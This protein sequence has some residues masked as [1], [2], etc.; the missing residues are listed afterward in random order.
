[1]LASCM[2]LCLLLGS[3]P[4]LSACTDWDQLGP[5]M[6]HDLNVNCLDSWNNLLV[7]ADDD[8]LKLVDRVDGMARV[9]SATLL[10]FWAEGLQVSAD[11]AVVWQ[12]ERLAGFHLGTPL[13]GPFFD[14][15]FDDGHV[16]SAVWFQDA[17]FV[18]YSYAVGMWG[19]DQAARRIDLSDPGH[20]IDLG[21]WPDAHML[22]LYEGCLLCCGPD[23]TVYSLDDPM[24]P[25][26]MA[27][28]GL[29][30]SNDDPCI[31]MDVAGG[32]VAAIIGG[33]NPG[34]LA[35]ADLTNPAQPGLIDL[36]TIPLTEVADGICFFDPQ[37]HNDE[38]LLPNYMEGFVSHSLSGMLP[39]SYCTR[40]WDVGSSP[41]SRDWIAMA[42]GAVW[43]ASPGENLR[44]L[45]LFPAVT[46]LQP[47]IKAFGAH[48]LLE[49]SDTAAA[50]YTVYR[51]DQPDFRD[52]VVELGTTGE[53]Q[54]LD[55]QALLSES[56]YYRV[57]MGRP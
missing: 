32:V 26:E 1:M 37:L 44:S 23:L 24:N 45:P 51:C 25:V 10:P 22:A 43:M 30:F 48:I 6:E 27:W 39:G 28:L 4:V 52:D 5:P 53:C 2:M 50:E 36:T 33:W 17:L 19:S 47:R 56:V 42:S 31:G 54:W 16:L 35:R 34:W 14:I 38:L 3:R 57:R 11:R 7:L 21:G 8:S 55:E 9:Q 20:P 29:G 13:E 12:A 49:W 15:P 41:L 40:L 46:L 18:S